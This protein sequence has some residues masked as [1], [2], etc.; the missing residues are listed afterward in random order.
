MWIP[1]EDTRQGLN[2]SDSDQLKLTG[3]A[4][5]WR[6]GFLPS[7]KGLSTPQLPFACRCPICT[8]EYRYLHCTSR[9][10]S[11]WTVLYT[12]MIRCMGGRVGVHPSAWSPWPSWLLTASFDL[13]EYLFTVYVCVG[14]TGRASR[15]CRRGLNCRNSW[16]LAG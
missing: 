7:S 11:I 9:F 14:R 3:E 13:P 2:H 16:S 15:K 1:Q 12:R 6:L 10:Q 5:T 4:S 8:L